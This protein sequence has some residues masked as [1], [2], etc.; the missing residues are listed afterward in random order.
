MNRAFCCII[1]M[2]LLP[3]V[4]VWTVTRPSYKNLKSLEEL[5]VNFLLRSFL[6]FVQKRDWLRRSPC[7]PVGI[8]TQDLQNRNLSANSLEIPC[9]YGL[10][11]LSSET[12]LRRFCADSALLILSI[13][14]AKIRISEWKTKFIWAF[15]SVSIFERSS[16]VIKML[17]TMPS[18]NVKF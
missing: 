8:Q 5:K 3:L 9:V 13:S 7:D 17:R 10:L 15:L 11:R 2:R 6:S 18:W 1:W 12:H 16:K 4:I 14:V